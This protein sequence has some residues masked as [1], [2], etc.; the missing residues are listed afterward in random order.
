MTQTGWSVLGGGIPEPRVRGQ[1]RP[2]RAARAGRIGPPARSRRTRS[3]RRRRPRAKPPRFQR[4]RR[5]ITTRSSSATAPAATATRRK[6]GGLSLAAFDV[7]HA[8][9]NA[10][11]AEKMIRKLQAG[12]MPPPR[13]A[14]PG[15]RDATR[16]SSARSRP[17]VDAAAAAQ[18]ESRR[19]HVPAPEPRRV[20]ARDQGSAR[21][22]RR[23]RRLAAARHDEREL[24]QHRR[25]AD[26]VADAARGVSE[27]GERRS[28]AWRSATGN[29]PAID[30]T[31][32]SPSYVSQ[33][34]WDHVEGAPYGT[35]GGMVVEHVFPADGEYVFEVDV[36]RR[37]QRAL[38]GRRHLGRRRARRARRVRDAAGRRRRRP[39]RRAD[40]DRADPRQ[41]RPAPVAAA[42]VRKVDGPYEDLIRPHDWSFAGG[43]SGGTGITTLPHLRDFI[44]SRAVQ[45][46]RHLR[47]AEPAA[48]SSRCRPTSR[49]RRARRARARSS[50]ASAA[51]RTAARSRAAEVDALMQFYDEGAAKGGFE[52]GV[53]AALE[54]ILASPHFIFRLEEQPA[55]VQAG[56]RRIASATSISR[57]GCRSSSGARRRTR[58]C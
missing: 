45:R 23:R 28:A 34:P 19:P 30:R 18:A 8:A 7:A 21:P 27:R 11:V 32:T 24:R 49:G 15:R 52:S 47:H 20:R 12:M 46:D 42:F 14:A 31:Y 2:A 57:R 44:D 13:R 33:H 40:A 10:E 17:T 6:T 36:H 5:R 53:R 29:A 54:A 9:Q 58:N 43:G 16:R 39:R 37:R 55:D 22:R 1:H 51:R 26:A 41:G 48:G 38:R 4:R 56:R 25:R 50:R 3:S 35:R